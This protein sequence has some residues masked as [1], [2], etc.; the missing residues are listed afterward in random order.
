MWNCLNRYA[1]SW[2]SACERWPERHASWEC[3]GGW[4]EKRCAERS[5]PRASHNEGG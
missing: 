2:S 3:T 5:L 4:C 1:L